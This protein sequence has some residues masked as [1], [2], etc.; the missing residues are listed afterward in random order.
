M[1]ASE[2]PRSTLAAQKVLWKTN[3]DQFVEYVVCPS[4]H[5]VYEYKDCYIIRHGQK[6]SKVCA[7]VAYPNHSQHSKRKPCGATLL[8][9]IKSG[10]SYKLSH[11]KVYPYQ[12]LQNSLSYLVQKRGFLDACEK[13]RSRMPLIPPTHLAHIYDGRV[14]SEFR[15]SGFL[16]SPFCY[17]LT[18]NIDWFQP[19]TE[20]SVGAIYLTI[21]NLPRSE[22][23]KD[24]NI[25]LVG[26]LPGPSE[27]TLTMNSYLAPL[28][29][30]LA[31]AWNSGITVTTYNGSS[32]NI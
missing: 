19:F 11:I 3:Q 10:K 23:Y 26:I 29:N 20:Y 27:P 9:N 4:C 16:E 7:H 1:T 18:L 12:P 30:D 28:V 14:L 8:K 22:R 25:F 17:L 6:E 15:S 2:I 31:K 5:S 21:Q 24:E 32:V 13:W